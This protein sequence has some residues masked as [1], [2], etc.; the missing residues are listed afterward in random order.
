MVGRSHHRSRGLLRL[1]RGDNNSG[2]FDGLISVCLTVTRL[3]EGGEGGDNYLRREELG[4]LTIILVV[5]QVVFPPDQETVKVSDN[6]RIFRQERIN[7]NLW[8]RIKQNNPFPFTFYI[9]M[10]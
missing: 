5:E 1:R 4:H 2:S 6:V 8:I 7:N 9:R 3:R 10:H